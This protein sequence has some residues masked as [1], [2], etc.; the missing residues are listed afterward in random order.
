MVSLLGTVVLSL[1]EGIRFCSVLKSGTCLSQKQSN[2]IGRIFVLCKFFLLC[3][4]RLIEADYKICKM[5]M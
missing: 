4:E 3:S 5:N 2:E 1:E